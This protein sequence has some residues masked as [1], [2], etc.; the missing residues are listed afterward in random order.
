M[1]TKCPLVSVC[2]LTYNHKEY[3][4]NALDSILIQKVDFEYELIIHDDSSTDGTVEVIKEY[5]NKHPSIIK[6][7]FQPENLMSSG[8]G[9][10]QLY[11]E[12]LLP[13]ANGK[14]IA[15]C[16]GDDYWTDI[17]KLQQQ[18]DFLENNPQSMICF[19]KVGI[20]KND[21]INFDIYEEYHRRILG[22]RTE[23]TITDLLKDNVIPNCSVVY[24]N[25]IC[26]YP[27]LFKDILFADW[28]LHLLYAEKGGIGYINKFMANHRDHE[29]G[30]WN[31]SS[32]ADRIKS[33][34]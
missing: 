16:E 17:N 18:I 23:F 11:T 29:N 20:Q 10:Y 13:K 6:P 2:C 33:N 19:H 1:S 3:I 4:K 7:I 22:D 27:K 32:F 31:G 26:E 24:R 8:I 15:I 25:I 12:Y 9:I 14:Y 34:I 28:P 30:L 5:T 21:H